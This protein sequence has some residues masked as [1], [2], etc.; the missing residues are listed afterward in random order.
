M[1]EV[2]HY[3]RRTQFWR[4]SGQKSI[5]SGDVGLEES[6]RD[7]QC[8]LWYSLLWYTPPGEPIC[9]LWQCGS[10][11]P[12]NRYIPAVKYADEKSETQFDTGERAQERLSQS[13]RTV[14]CTEFPRAE[15]KESSCRK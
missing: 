1:P 7:T 15:E 4:N 5:D 10:R 8:H 3:I 2:T 13:T 11:H 6:W 9:P 12:K 14:P